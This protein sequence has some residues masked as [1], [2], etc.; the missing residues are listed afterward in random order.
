ME[1]WNA[2]A[3]FRGLKDPTVRRHFN[4]TFVAFNIDWGDQGMMMSNFGL[5][6]DVVY[7]G[8]AATDL[9]RAR[10]ETGLPVFFFLWSPH[11]FN[12]RYSLNRIQLPAYSPKQLREGLSDFPTDVLEKVAW[13]GLADLAP[14][15]AELYMRL[16]MD[17]AAQE[18]MLA[19]I[20]G[21]GLSVMQS[22]CAWLRKKENA[23]VWRA[24]LPA[25]K[26]ACDVGHYVVNQTSCAPCPAG[27]GSVGGTA[28]VCV[29][30][31]PGIR[32]YTSILY[33]SWVQSRARTHT[34]ADSLHS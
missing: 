4:N 30:C 11:A 1:Q 5:E 9:I 13:K 33:A 8:F 21:D 19:T 15:V 29:Q 25:E 23:A 18:S 27:S 32:R 20:E 24:W 22:A 2:L 17:N 12:I 10:L 31:S 34:H 7:H 16:R 28:S 26:H 3:G 14:A 6:Y